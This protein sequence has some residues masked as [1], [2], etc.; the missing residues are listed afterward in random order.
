[1]K[2]P[3]K[4]DLQQVVFNLLNTFIKYITYIKLLHIL[5]TL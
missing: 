2:I 4:Q 5:N 3:N 1:M